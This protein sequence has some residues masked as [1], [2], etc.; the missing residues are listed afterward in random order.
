MAAGT[1]RRT[2]ERLRHHYEVEKEIADRLKAARDPVARARIFATMYDELFERVPDHPRLTVQR[3]PEAERRQVERLLVILGPHLKPDIEYVEFGAGSCALAFT[4]A[5]RVRRVRVVEIA[6]QIPASVAR[7]ENFELVL[8]DGFTL[9]LPEG[10]ADVVFSEQF[11]EHLHPDDAERHF[12][13]VH[14]ILRPGGRYLLRTPE[15]WTGPHDISRWFSD[16]P[17]GF[18]LR[19]W[20][21]ADLVRTA[22][23]AG[24]RA[25]HAYWTG[26]GQCLRWPL[27]AALAVE[28]AVAHMPLGM[29]RTLGHK[30]VPMVALALV[31]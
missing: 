27:P 26:R 22:R 6:D 11:V 30:L 12:A 5:P 16:A 7:P 29:R 1:D 21:Y 25:Q 8:Y 4:V 18:H 13:L 3:D 10:T 24:Y 23:G 9:D 17:R 20:S 28:R 2:P 15:R 31:K 19:E 14:R